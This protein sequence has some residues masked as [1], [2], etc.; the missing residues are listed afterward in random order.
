MSHGLF[1]CVLTACVHS[2]WLCVVSGK[3]QLDSPKQLDD[4]RVVLGSLKKNSQL[5]VDF[6]AHF[7]PE[8]MYFKGFFF[9]FFVLAKVLM[10]RLPFVG[11]I[12]LF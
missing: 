10:L 4:T 9:F 2:S 12:C 1:L 8:I 5:F 7:F 3:K 6:F 11:N